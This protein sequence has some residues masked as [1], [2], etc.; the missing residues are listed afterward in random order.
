MQFLVVWCFALKLN[1]KAG[2]KN[3]KRQ[4]ENAHRTVQVSGKVE[5]FPWIFKTSFLLSV[6]IN[7]YFCLFL[8]FHILDIFYA[9]LP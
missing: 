2:I 1:Y 9:E 5:E 3:N 8:C 6:V 4:R 7:S